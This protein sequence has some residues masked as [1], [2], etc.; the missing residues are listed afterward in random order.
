M[1]YLPV[2]LSPW[3]W[4]LML[5]VAPL[6]TEPTIFELVCGPDRT[7][8]DLPLLVCTVAA[9]ACPATSTA[10]SAAAPTRPA[11]VTSR[12]IDRG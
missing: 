6:R 2:T 11:R 4:Q 8:N 12:R 1:P 3:V 10:A 9:D 5:T 7:F